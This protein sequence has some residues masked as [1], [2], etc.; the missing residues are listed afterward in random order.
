MKAVLI[1]LDSV[2]IGSAPDA[3]EYGDA[4]ASTLPHLAAAAGGVQLPTMQ[5][6]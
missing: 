5:K 4:G 1:I 3:A 2:G 6:M